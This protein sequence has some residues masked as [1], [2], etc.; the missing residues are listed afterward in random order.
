MKIRITSLLALLLTIAPVA[1]LAQSSQPIVS[2][3]VTEIDV[4]G[5]T[6]YTGSAVNGGNGPYTDSITIGT[7]EQGAAPFTVAYF[8]NGVNIG[9]GTMYSFPSPGTYYVSASV[10]DAN[11]HT[12]NSVAVQYYATGV[13]IVNPLNGTVVPA[14]S[15]VV[16]QAAAGIA[17]GAPAQVEFFLGAATEPFAV[18]FNYPYQTI[19]TPQTGAG[20]QANIYAVAYNPPAS[21]ES[22]PLASLPSNTAAN[23]AGNSTVNAILIESP[24]EAPPTCVI[25]TPTGS[26]AGTVPGPTLIPIPNYVANSSATISVLVDAEPGTSTGFITKVELYINGVLFG[27][28]TGYP[29]SFAWAPTVTGTYNLTALAYDD[30]NNVVASTTGT[31]GALTPQPTTVVITPLPSVAITSPN[32]GAVLNSGA[33]TTITASATDAVGILNVQFFQ[34]GT[35]LG[36]ATAPDA[37]TTNSYSVTFKPVQNIQTDAN[38]NPQVLPSKLV[39][40]AADTLGASQT[41]PTITVT[42]TAGGSG[43]GTTVIG[44]PP[45]SAITSPATS[46]S[47]IVNTP[48]TIMVA[49]TA[50]NGNIAQVAFLIDGALVAAPITKYPY[51]FVWT[52]TNLGTY[53]V[54]AA[55]TDN[56]GDVT[57]SAPISITVVTEPPPTVNITSPTSGGTVTV[58]TTVAINANA[59]SASGTIASVQFFENGIS[60]GTVTGSPFTFNWTPTTTGLFTLTAIATDNAGETTT[61]GSI[62]V[63]AEPINTAAGTTTYF[64]TYQGLTA[65][66]G[67]TFAFVTN[68]GVLGTFIGI[69]A[70][71]SS[72]TPV[73]FV[74]DLALGSF[75][76]GTG[77]TATTSVAF[78]GPAVNGTASATGVSGTLTPSNN[79]FIGAPAVSNN[80]SIA[81][82]Y[83][84]GNLEAQPGTNVTAIVGPDGEIMVYVS[85]GTFADAGYGSY[86]SV[87]ANGQFSVTTALGNTISGTVNPTTGF[88]TGTLVGGPGGT[89]LAARVSGGT[90]SDGVLR[91]ISTRGDVQ[92]GSNIMIA[93]FVVGGTQNKN[94]LIR[95]SGPTLTAFG[96]SGAIA[97]T[98]LSV[99][100]GA[101]VVASNT[102]W[103]STT[104]NQNAVQAADTVSGA[105][106]FAVGSA[107]S[108]LVGSFAPGAYTAMVSGVGTDT[109]VSLVEVYDLDTFQPF[110]TNKLTNIST[111]GFVGTG[112]DIIIGGF[113]ING[114]APK[115]VLIRADGPALTALGVTGA[116]AAPRLQL[117]NSGGSPIRENY[118]WQ[119]GNDP[120]LISAAESATGAFTLAKGSNDAAILVVLPPGIYTAEVSGVGSA[121]GT[122]LFEVYEVP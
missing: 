39:A 20:T 30:K 83:Y 74:Q 110:M 95:A 82:G 98:E 107:D 116:L 18:S 112:S 4:T 76:Q 84:T 72:K 56:V 64:G 111:R 5:G 66:D 29:Y 91:N 55:V 99:Y 36:T 113:Y 28:D 25:T 41:S 104:V 122:A 109:G 52:P 1:S 21:A 100:S 50:P 92:T 61:S 120:G 97:A 47:V 75:T 45:T 38:G 10:T 19:F 96:L 14:G 31:A 117:L 78:T 8:I 6:D 17:F 13:Q 23:V 12:A 89:V 37:G 79:I 68:D 22:T 101:T 42:V 77:T 86:S 63:E 48:T 94:L 59:V 46:T 85:A 108:A 81:Y 27:T 51:Q 71:S 40:I 9:A 3:S 57:N 102:G 16:I 65:A 114:S 105:F 33:T 67:G 24:A 119:A 26:P 103:S 32:N 43:G 58:G 73:T 11:G 54:V 106:A 44:T 87:N 2:I 93:G 88:M 49:A 35:Y 80:V 118:A 7:T 53:Q 62:I 69:S 60:L 70:D 15:S 121:T 115:R 90:F 34:D